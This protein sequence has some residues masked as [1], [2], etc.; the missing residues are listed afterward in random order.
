MPFPS[1]LS[2][3]KRKQSPPSFIPRAALQLGHPAASPNDAQAQ[4]GINHTPQRTLTTNLLLTHHDID[5][6]LDLDLLPPNATPADEVQRLEA[7]HAVVTKQ[8]KQARLTK[9]LSDLKDTVEVLT[10]TNAQMRDQV[11]ALQ[12]T[13]KEH[14]EEA[15]QNAELRKKIVEL[16]DQV[17][18]YR[19]VNEDLVGEVARLWGMWRG[20]MVREALRDREEKLGEKEPQSERGPRDGEKGREGEQER[21]IKTPRIQRADPP[22]APK[23]YGEYRPY[24]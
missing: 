14:A 6:D 10:M 23:A 22:L 15:E 7:V 13:N 12:T 24:R 11:K 2:P 8:L 17:G 1:P 19:R 16:E 20:C 4:S 9:E 5:L 3:R 21:D 18:H